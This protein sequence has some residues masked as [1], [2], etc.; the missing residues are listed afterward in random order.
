M[1]MCGHDYK[2]V[3]V[4]TLVV[5]MQAMLE[6]DVS[7][8]LGKPKALFGF[9]GDKMRGIRLEDVWKI[10]TVVSRVFQVGARHSTNLSAERSTEFSVL[11]GSGNSVGERRCTGW[12]ACA[13]K[14]I[15]K[16]LVVTVILRKLLLSSIAYPHQAIILRG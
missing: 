4:K 2:C 3:D 1:S 10:A 12:R 13:T 16:G 9:E 11:C 5:V 15:E 6:D 14:S 7:S 8:G